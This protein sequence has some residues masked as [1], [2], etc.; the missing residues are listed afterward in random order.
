MNALIGILGKFGLFTPDLDYKL[1]RGS[2]VITFFIFGYAKW[3]A[4]DVPLLMP[5][6]SK[7]PLIFWL[8]PAFGPRG[9]TWFLGTS[10]WTIGTL[11]LLGFW[12]KKLG[13][14]GALGSV[15]TFIC[16]VTIIPVVPDG[17]E[18]S[19]GGFPAMTMNSAFLMK[20]LVLLAV[21]VYLLKQD[22]LRV[23]SGREVY[24]TLGGSAS[25]GM[26]TG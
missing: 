4:Y 14:L 1:L 2:M 24:A 22:A 17:W 6:I 25:R 21:S 16:T 20:D 7:G 11:L 5:L 9:A 10:E 18:P 15:G 3:F 19:A 26:G 12:N 13:M 23:S 8:Y